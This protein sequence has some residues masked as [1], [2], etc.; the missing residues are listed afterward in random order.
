VYEVPF[1]LTPEKAYV[2]IVFNG[3]TTGIWKLG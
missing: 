1:S 3:N 2:E